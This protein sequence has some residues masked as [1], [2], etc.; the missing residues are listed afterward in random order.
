MKFF[1]EPFAFHVL[2]VDKA[3]NFVG[4]DQAQALFNLN[5]VVGFYNNFGKM[6]K[7]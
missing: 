5:P 3:Q 2:A 7:G 1:L 4:G 6:A